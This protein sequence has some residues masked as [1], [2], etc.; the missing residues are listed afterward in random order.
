MK[1][2][3]YK[4]KENIYFNRKG[5]IMWLVNKKRGIF[6]SLLFAFIFLVYIFNV[7]SESTSGV[8][9]AN[10]TAA[11]FTP[12]KSGDQDLYT[13]DMST[14]IS[15]GEVSGRGGLSMPITVGYSSGIKIGEEA[16]WVGLGWNIGF[17]AITRSVNGVPD[18]SQ[19]G[20]LNR[21]YFCGPSTSGVLDVENYYYFQPQCFSDYYSDQRDY[22][23][24]DSYY[25]NFGG[26]GGRLLVN[27]TPYYWDPLHPDAD[28]I[29]GFTSKFYTQ[30]WRPTKIDYTTDSDGQ[31]RKWIVTT[32]DGTTYIFDYFEQTNITPQQRIV[33][34][35][36]DMNRVEN[37]PYDECHD[38]IDN[39]GDGKIDYYWGGNDGQNVDTVS[40]PG[41]NIAPYTLESS[42]NP[43]VYIAPQCSDLLDNDNDGRIDYPT[44]PD[45]TDY[46]DNQESSSS[47]ITPTSPGGTPGGSPFVR[48]KAT[49][50]TTDNFFLNL[51]SAKKDV[52][53]KEETSYGYTNVYIA[54]GAAGSLGEVI[55]PGCSGTGAYGGSSPGAWPK[56]ESI[57]S[58]N[59]NK[60]YYNYAGCVK[61][62]PSQSYRTTWLLTEIRSPDFVD[63]N[64]N[65]IAES[66]DKG[67]WIKIIYK[68]GVGGIQTYVTPFSPLSIEKDWR[69][70][71]NICQMVKTLK[72][73]NPSQITYDTDSFSYVGPLGYSLAED[74][75]WNKPGSTD[76]FVNYYR[77]MTYG[78]IQTQT[79]F[80]YVDTINTST[81]YAKFITSQR[82]DLLRF[83]NGV[84][85]AEKL[86]R[87]EVYDKT[88][89]TLLYKYEFNY[90]YSLAKQSI[91]PKY[92]L[93][94][95]PNGGKLTLKNITV[96][97][98]SGSLSLPPYEFAYG[99]N[100]N[101]SVYAKDW[102]G[103]FND[104][105]TNNGLICA[106]LDA[107]KPTLSGISCNQLS[108]NY[109]ECY[110]E[111]QRPISQRAC[112]L[113]GNYE[114]DTNIN[115]PS[116]AAW[117]L[118]K[119]KYPTGGE[120]SYAYE[121]DTYR[122][123]QDRQI[124]SDKIGGG[125]R[126]KNVTTD[127]KLGDVE[128]TTYFYDENGDGTGAS[129][130]V[131]TQN[132][133]IQAGS[134][135]AFTNVAPGAQNYV[136]YSKV[137]SV[138]PSKTFGGYGKT[139]VE[140]YTPKDVPDLDL[141][142]NG[143]AHSFNEWKRGQKKSVKSYDSLGNLVSL[144]SSTWDFGV[145]LNSALQSGQRPGE[146]V[147]PVC[148]GNLISCSNRNPDDCGGVGTG[149]TTQSIAGCD[150]PSEV[151]YDAQGTYGP[152][153]E[154]V[155]INMTKC[156]STSGGVGGPNGFYSGGIWHYYGTVC[157]I[158]NPNC[159]GFTSST[160]QSLSN[161]YCRWDTKKRCADQGSVPFRSC[162]QISIGDCAEKYTGCQPANDKSIYSGW[163][164]LVQETST[165]DGV[166]NI[167][168][169]NYNSKNGLVDTKTETNSD[170]KKR[171]T[172]INYTVDF[173][174]STSDYPRA[175]PE[176]I[177]KNMLT[178][179]ALQEVY[180][181][182]KAPENK[183]A[184]SYIY[185]KNFGLPGEQRWYLDEKGEQRLIYN[186]V[187]APTYDLIIKTIFNAYDSYGNIFTITD[188]LGNVIE[189]RYDAVYNTYPVKGWNSVIGS[190][191]TPAW[192]LT[193]NSFGN[194]ISSKDSNTK[195]T[196]YLYDALGRLLSVKRPSDTSPTTFY[197]YNYVGK[198]I[199]DQ[200]LNYV[201]TRQSISSGLNLDTY[202]YADGLGVTLNNTVKKVDLGQPADELF[203]NVEYNELGNVKKTT[204]P[205]FKTSP[206]TK[207]TLNYY[208]ADPLSRL[209][210]VVPA[211]STGDTFVKYDYLN[212][213]SAGLR[214][215]RVTDEEAKTT[216]SF[217]DKFGNL[218]KVIDPAQYITYYEYDELG[219]LTKIINSENRITSNK[220][221]SLGRLLETTSPDFG[222][223]TYTYDLNG[224]KITK[225]QN[226][227]T[228]NYDYDKINRLVQIRYPEGDSSTYQYDSAPT[229][230][231]P[232]RSLN[233]GNEKSRLTK[234]TDRS[235][236]SC[237]YYDS[238][239]QL[240]YKVQI[241]DGKQYNF[242]F[243]YDLAGNLINVVDPLGINTTYT[244]NSL[245]Q[246]KSVTSK[247][248]TVT[249][250]YNPSGSIK[251]I[252]FPNSVS[253]SYQYN[254]REWVTNIATTGLKDQNG[255][256]LVF[257]DIVD[258]DKVGNV[259][260]RTDNIGTSVFSYD[261]LYRL[262]G[263]NPPA[264]QPITGV[265]DSFSY[266]YD[267]IGNRLSENDNAYTY[268]PNTNKLTSVTNSPYNTIS[269]SFTYDLNGN[270]DS[271]TQRDQA[272]IC[273]T[274][275]GPS[276]HYLLYNIDMPVG[277][278]VRVVYDVKKDDDGLSHHYEWDAE[279]LAYS[280]SEKCGPDFYATNFVDLSDANKFITYPGS[281]T[282]PGSF[283][284]AVHKDSYFR[285]YS[286]G[287]HTT[288]YSFNSNNEL[289]KI[290]YADGTCDKFIYDSNSNRIKKTESKEFD[291][292]RVTVLSTSTAFPISK[293]VAIDSDSSGN[294]YFV[295]YDTNGGSLY[296]CTPNLDSCA[297]LN[298]AIK[299]AT[300]LAVDKLT[301]DILVN[302]KNSN[303]DPYHVIQRINKDTG[304][305][306]T[307]YTPSMDVI[308]LASDSAGWIYA[309]TLS[310]Y[311]DIFKD[312]IH[313]T[314][315]LGGVQIYSLS[316]D[317]DGNI[318]LVTGPNTNS[319][320]KLNNTLNLIK[321]YGT[322][323][324]SCEYN[325]YP[326]GVSVSSGGY[327]YVV[328]NSGQRLYKLDPSLQ[329]YK[330]EIF[331]TCS[332]SGTDSNSL[333]NPSGV[334]ANSN[335]I[336]VA[337]TDNNRILK[338]NSAKK[339]Y[340][341]RYLSGGD[342]EY[343]ENEINNTFSC[344]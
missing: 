183:I 237:V 52:L 270:I 229:S 83:D 91:I 125:L 63:S 324:G 292:G 69:N 93:Y 326:R 330:L 339:G 313:R 12:I 279:V 130:G 230:P 197:N 315:F 59:K 151:C 297:V 304:A 165:V 265:Y 180:K 202:S 334:N 96:K 303:G 338:F 188:P 201:N 225:R 245:N 291:F 173:P 155:G 236:V 243:V 308:G 344:A 164:R 312:D 106:T 81:N 321:S 273:K 170:G 169:Y 80:S 153:C 62:S 25:L 191:T 85:S 227:Q 10:P 195:E 138:L 108:F 117:S 204:V 38:L 54:P 208:K 341:T 254:P 203:S 162:S 136:A 58:T 61:S 248:K 23:R 319:V 77:T 47:T 199:S 131:A 147:A 269:T 104:K 140:F 332:V 171:I 277:T 89:N 11:S 49:E 74:C 149:C 325:K 267:K 76:S 200:N 100:P 124:P 86:D 320:W 146:S 175:Y 263:V 228:I 294:V 317:L 129:S 192:Q 8:S 194:I 255:L 152:A 252:N 95:N 207:A 161:P 87:I 150:G 113:R 72:N 288:T 242:D 296:K 281:I 115:N 75:E 15:L 268:T 60:A 286:S 266:T 13:G 218:V 284:S 109:N 174:L 7:H 287:V 57:S 158:Y 261:N 219:R 66:S 260:T 17:G 224:N 336:Y 56:T 238:K 144:S 157:E 99:S 64:G 250:D 310:G 31:I 29:K 314:K 48:K 213:V 233:A 322:S 274:K 241:V 18:D 42:A 206:T 71:T 328:D 19:F 22:G 172:K 282:P 306:I 26:G 53:A 16:S 20:Y 70:M 234:I 133:S 40:D 118:T 293:P 21:D 190:S 121:P 105:T 222:T 246:L 98:A 24:I 28:G 262:T 68:K 82:Y 249:Y 67:N 311:I 257:S 342:V 27:Q 139:I 73:E 329:G 1:E 278:Q 215:V 323:S 295:S 51:F 258:Y 335:G 103:Y 128:T 5:I 102:W 186:P 217:Y 148:Q 196:T 290:G 318:Y 302:H 163:P 4:Q 122:Y 143:N 166:T 168:D 88:S 159:G 232:V 276:G 289:T 271:Q 187:G 45:C 107:T 160:C 247:S 178:Q 141:D 34:F 316:V 116:A 30:N 39:D 264:G 43:P 179:V 221:D 154:P 307:T 231:C 3:I 55:I 235:G 78:R 301:G 6:F 189:T 185:Y 84:A 145:N 226:T 327:V 305:I 272:T 114:P 184:I 300:A 216:Q 92:Y 210:R 211:G 79:E 41:C 285:I 35:K 126:I 127:N 198:E 205:F 337:D 2:K 343:Q 176:M 331:G 119:I 167:I 111:S 134:L 340:I 14:S 37:I 212:D 214:V 156:T 120:I 259:M 239:G 94:Q 135:S 275:P 110:A 181:D 32:E 209:D 309:G 44:D 101:Y 90:D 193:Y 50:Q 33:S 220:Y 333:K 299:Y 97:D 132:S 9:G 253:T 256:P 123:I 240:D 251:T 177:A 182:S 298:N 46:L 36:Q 223:I 280:G 244:Y 142:A 283:Y 65:G 112:E 137:T